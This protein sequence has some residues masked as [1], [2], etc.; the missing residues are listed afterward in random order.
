MP[1]ICDYEGS[2][3]RSEFWGIRDRQY[4]DAVERI[5]ISKLLPARGV[6]LIEIGAGFG[7]LANLYAGYEQVVLGLSCK[8]P[9]TI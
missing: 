8:K 3:Y 7:R 4:E 6:R 2:Q 5:A 1:R 9:R